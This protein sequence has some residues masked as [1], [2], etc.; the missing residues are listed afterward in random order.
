MKDYIFSFNLPEDDPEC[1]VLSDEKNRG[2][3]EQQIEPLGYLVTWQSGQH[4]E[5]LEIQKTDSARPLH[6]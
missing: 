2:H 4:Y 3:L 1:F 6:L 5:I